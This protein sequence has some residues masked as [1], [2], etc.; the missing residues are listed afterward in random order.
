MRTYL[1]VK[2]IQRATRKAEE[3]AATIAYPQ[4]GR[5]ITARLRSWF[6]VAWNTDC[7]GA[8]AAAA[9]GSRSIDAYRA[10]GIGRSRRQADRLP[11]PRYLRGASRP[12]R[13]RRRDHRPG[14]AQFHA[15]RE[16]A[17]AAT[18]P[19]RRAANLGSTSRLFA[20]TRPATRGSRSSRTSAWDRKR[21]QPPRCTLPAQTATAGACALGRFPTQKRVPRLRS[22]G[23]ESVRGA[24]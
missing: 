23:H 14:V 1:P 13:A 10:E 8:S 21:R 5:A 7:G 16:G 20:R 11:T 15:C 12:A 4:P 22:T 17:G 3:P 9:F 18:G 2:D 6:R 19:T 24:T